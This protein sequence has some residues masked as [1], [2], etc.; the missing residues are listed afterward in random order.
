MESGPRTETNP[1]IKSEIRST[2]S[3][4]NR[5][6]NKSQNPENPK[7]RIEIEV[8]LNFV[9]FGTF[10]FVSDFEFRAYKF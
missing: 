2:K 9:F 1:K 4:T 5:G 3:E 8:V 10:E 7:L 6:Q